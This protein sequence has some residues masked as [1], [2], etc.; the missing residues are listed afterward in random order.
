MLEKEINKRPSSTEL[1]DIIIREY[2]KKITKNSSISSLI[3]CLF[4]INDIEKEFLKSD[5]SKFN[6]KN[7]TPIYFFRH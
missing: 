2:D 3:S 5:N 6:N 1:C 7:I 4:S